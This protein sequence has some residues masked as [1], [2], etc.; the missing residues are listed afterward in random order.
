MG[1]RPHNPALFKQTQT[2]IAL[3]ASVVVTLW[4]QM[5]NRV[6]EVQTILGH[7][8]PAL[9]QRYAHLAPGFGAAAVAAIDGV[10]EM[11][12]ISRPSNG[13]EKSRMVADR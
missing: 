2:S 5:K 8:S 6:S 7:S 3:V 11:R 1:V 10:L 4:S 12:D 9:T 13:K